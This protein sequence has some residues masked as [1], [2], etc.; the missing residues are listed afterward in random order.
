MEY[1]EFRAMNTQIVLAAEGASETL[2]A[3]FEQTHASI[4]AREAQFTRFQDTSEL[5]AMN[6]A[7]GT[8]FN[9]SPEMFELMQ[10]AQ[11][12]HQQTKGL[13]NPAILGALEGAGYDAS[14][15]IVRA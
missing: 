1:F 8:W 15:E 13:F 3:A 7:A 2:A 14:L 12:Y 5:A 6:R 10:T 9:C 11:E 4:A